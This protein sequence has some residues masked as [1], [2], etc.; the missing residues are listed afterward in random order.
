MRYPATFGKFL[1]NMSLPSSVR[2]YYEKRFGV[3]LVSWAQQQRNG[4]AHPL[5]DCVCLQLSLRA[6][7]TSGL[8]GDCNHAWRHS[9][10]HID[11]DQAVWNIDVKPLQG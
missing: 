4:D 1:E 6:C 10:L 9:C 5:S 11:G 8:L 7:R 2:S 3:Y